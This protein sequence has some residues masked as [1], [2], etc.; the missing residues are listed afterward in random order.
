M[1]YTHDL[2]ATIGSY[3]TK[4]GEEKKRYTKCGA[5]F[6]DDD[7]RLS[8]KM[9]SV[10]VSSEWSGWFSMYPKKEYDDAPQQ[11]RQSSEPARQ[12]ASGSGDGKVPF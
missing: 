11:S 10:P 4:S 9:D 8:I 12:S 5:V 1:N 6:T 7:G 2:V 3:T